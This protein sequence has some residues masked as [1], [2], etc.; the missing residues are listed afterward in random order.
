MFP[1]KDI[2]TIP[3]ECPL[4]EVDLD[5]DDDDDCS[6]GDFCDDQFRHIEP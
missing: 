5:L 6:C 4:E 3:A 2:N 1:I